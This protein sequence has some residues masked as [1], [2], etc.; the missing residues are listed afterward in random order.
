MI[1]WLPY[2]AVLTTTALISTHILLPL[3]G[4]TLTAFSGGI[5]L[6]VLGL[7]NWVLIQDVDT[8]T[9]KL[10]EINDHANALSQYNR[11]LEERN[12]WLLDF[13]TRFDIHPRVSTVPSLKPKSG[14]LVPTLKAVRRASSSDDV[15]MSSSNHHPKPP[16]RYHRGDAKP[17]Q[18]LQ[19]VTG[20]EL[21][22]S[23]VL[24]LN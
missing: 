15:S 2:L 22:C 5:I 24:H 23:S 9:A 21:P 16:T 7:E 12:Y 3:L 1:C 19:I 6:A 4:P 14:P 10:K 20:S 11:L 13:C 17:K 8:N 18:W